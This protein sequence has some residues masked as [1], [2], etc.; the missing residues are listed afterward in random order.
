MPLVILF[1]PRRDILARV[2]I[3]S[4]DG[5]DACPLRID[6]KEVQVPDIKI[7]LPLGDRRGDD[8]ARRRGLHPGQI[9]GPEALPSLW[10][11]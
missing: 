5:Q 8:M 7:T 3:V 10:Q 9:S 2:M 11:R 1:E 4:G 6:G